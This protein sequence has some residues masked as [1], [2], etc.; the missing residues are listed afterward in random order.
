MNT[1][2]PVLSITGSDNTGA[3]GIQADIKTITAMG[4]DALTAL[5]A[6]TVQDSR[7][8]SNILDLPTDMVVGQV[9]A[10]IDDRHPKVVKVGMLRQ[11]ETIHALHH[12]IV[13][14]PFKVMVPGILTAHNRLLLS[15]SAIAAWKSEL[16]PEATLLIVRCNEAEL[17]LGRSIVTD[18]DMLQ[19]AK[20][21]VEWGT[22]FVL[23]RGGHQVA[24]QLTTLLY[25][26]G[27][28]QFFTSQNTE[29]WL[30]H[31]I[32][33]ALSSAIATRLAFGDDISQ[34]ISLAHAYMH[35]QVVYAVENKNQSH[36]MADHYNLLMTLIAANYR[37]AHDVAF[38]ADHMAITPRYLTKVT[39]SVV[40]KS[41]KQ[42]IDDYLMKESI[43]LLETSRMSIGEIA[44]KLGYSSLAM[45][46]NFFR[47]HQGCS[48][49]EYRS[50]L[51]K[52]E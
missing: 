32:R 47:A 11:P 6:V 33:G 20:R 12:E 37:E 7:G 31:G 48:P 40:G 8:I 18:D 14:I 2:T 19:A 24:G 42:V 5:T 28:R 36:R 30:R 43:S 39:D 45:F 52:T 16:L 17:L 41:P 51:G 26:T 21:L 23:L 13:G 9:K 3:S 27:I 44:S 35:S 49:K 46:S 15:E 34:A 1:L 29:G 10:I 22:Q 25:G 50:S 38:Y 4:G